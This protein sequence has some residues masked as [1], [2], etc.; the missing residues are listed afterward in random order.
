MDNPIIEL[1][2]LII[3]LVSAWKVF[4]MAGRPGWAVLIPIYNFY[5]LLDI[6]DQPG[7]YVLLLFVPIV[8]I[9]V[10]IF[11]M[12]AL[13]GKFGRGMGFGLGLAFLPFIFFPILAFREPA[14]QP[15]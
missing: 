2:I 9:F 15:S 1:A 12:I 8:N 14:T 11:T 13:A 6:A 3:T 4:T 5:V 7:W 10:V